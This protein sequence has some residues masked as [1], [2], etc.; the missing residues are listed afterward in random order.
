ML[1]ILAAHFGV[2]CF[3]CC[4]VYMSLVH[5]ISTRTR[6]VSHVVHMFSEVVLIKIFS[7][8]TSVSVTLIKYNMRY[9]RC[10]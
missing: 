3:D 4:G 10:I 6:Q 9:L 1:I 7:R 5:V 8:K 2:E